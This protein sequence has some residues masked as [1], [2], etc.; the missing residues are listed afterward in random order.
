MGKM[1]SMDL[2]NVPWPICILK[3]NRKI[4]EMKPGDTLNVTLVDAR[5]RDNL[6]LL[7]N[8]LSGLQFKFQNTVDGYLLQIKKAG[9]GK[10]GT[11]ANKRRQPE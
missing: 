2:V 11:V 8:A 6:V 9:P 4:D 10:A 7:L 5:V 1:S 3:C